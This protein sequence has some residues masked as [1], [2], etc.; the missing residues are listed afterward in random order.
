[1]T[2]LHLQGLREETLP[3]IFGQYLKSK[4]YLWRFQMGK[5]K[6]EHIVFDQMLRIRKSI[7]VS[8]INSNC[9]EK[10]KK[11]GRKKNGC[12]EILCLQNR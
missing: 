11:G 8:K 3:W 9:K 1:M 6:R 5:K 10:G 4:L 2:T 7:P 12:K